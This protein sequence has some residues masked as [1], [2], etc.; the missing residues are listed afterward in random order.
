[1]KRFRISL[2][3]VG[4]FA[5]L[6][7]AS[8]QTVAS[9][10]TGAC[11]WA[12]TGSG[13]DLTLTITGNGKMADY[14]TATAV[15]WFRDYYSNITSITITQGVTHIGKCAF[16]ACYIASA[17]TIPNSVTSIGDYAFDECKK[18]TAVTIPNSVTS[19]SGVAFR[20]CTKLTTLSV[21]NDNPSY[22]A[23]NNVLFN[24][25]KTTL[26]YCVTGKTGS[27]TIPNSVTSIGDNAFYRCNVNSVIIPNSVTSIGNYAFCDCS[28]LTGAT[29]PNSVTSIGDRA[30]SG[31][32]NLTGALTI[33]NSVTSIGDKAFYDCSKLTGALT[34]PN[35]V[36][37]IGQNAFHN[38]SNTYIICW[39]TTP[40]TTI[41]AGTISTLTVYVL[42][43]ALSLYKNA[44]WW[45]SFYYIYNISYTIA[46]DGNSN[47]GGTTDN[48]SHDYGEMQMLASNGFTRTGYTFAG[49]NTEKNGMGISYT[50]AQ[51]V[52]N[53]TAIL[54]ATI[55]LYAQWTPNHTI[56]Y[57][58]NGGANHSSNPATYTVN[59]TVTLHAPTR[60][61][62]T[63]EGWYDNDGFNGSAVGGISAG[64]TGSKSY[65]ARWTAHVY[66]VAYEGNSATGGETDTS[67]HVYDVDKALTP[68][69]FSRTGYTFTG[70]A[71]S[72][73]GE[74]VYD[75]TLT[76]SMLTDKNDV[77]LTLYA[78]W[79]AHA[80]RV[81]YDGNSATDGETDTSEHV[82][83]V[84]KQLT[85]NGFARMDYLFW[86]WAT[87]P[88]GGKVYG[89][90]QPV[91]NLTSADSAT[92][93]LY[94][95][96][97]AD[98][99]NDGIPDVNDP[100]SPA[101][102]AA[103]GGC[104]DDDGDGIPN[105]NDPDSP[106][107]Q[108]PGGGC[109]DGDEDGVPNRND[110]DAPNCWQVGGS[111]T[112]ED[113]G[114][115]MLRVVF[116]ANYGVWSS[117]ELVRKGKPVAPPAK[118][119]A[120]EG[121]VF[122]GWFGVGS[123]AWDFSTP[124]TQNMTLQGRWIDENALCAVAFESNGGSAVDTQRVALGK[125]VQRP[126]NPVRE[127]Y[128]FAGWYK[129]ASLSTLWNFPTDVAM[130]N[131][132]LYAKWYA[133][134]VTTFNI[135]FDSRGGTAVDT[136]V[137]AL[138]E[139]LQP[140]AD[141]VREGYDF[142]GWWY[143]YN[144]PRKYDFSR[145]RAYEDKLLYA[146]WEIRTYTVSFE[147]NGSTVD[148]QTVAHGGTVAH[149]AADPPGGK[150]G[151]AFSGWY[152]DVGFTAPWDFAN[153]TVV[154]DTTLYA[155]WE[156]SVIFETNSGT[157]IPPHK[158][159]PGE[160]LPYIAQ[161]TRKNYKFVGWFRD[162][163][164]LFPWDTSRHFVDDG[165]M[166]LYAGWELERDEPW[167][168]SVAVRHDGG[169]IDTLLTLPFRYLLACGDS[170]KALRVALRLPSGLTSSLP[171][172]TLTL[173]SLKQA[174]RIDTTVILSTSHAITPK[175]TAYTITLERKFTFDS[176]V[177]TQ[178]G[179]RLLMVVN[180]PDNNGGYR[181]QRAWWRANSGAWFDI[182]GLSGTR[183]MYYVDPNGAPIT[184]S[185]S[186]RLQDGLTGWELET[187]PAAPPA[188]PPVDSAAPA[189]PPVALYPNPVPAGGV[190]HL[191]AAA[192]R[193]AAL[194]AEHPAA[195]YATYRL[196]DVQGRL[197]RSGSASELQNGLRMPSIP[198][199]YFLV[200]EGKTGKTTLLVISY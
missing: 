192:G 178:L 1:M 4:F 131:I 78:A 83:D 17:V 157:P 92:V 32:Y 49:W 182:S 70:W 60:T 144:E 52:S 13:S 89:N 101:C 53:L 196:L 7:A 170:T 198:G 26:V 199:S 134:S 169:R 73:G 194:P 86:G 14:T 8:A 122:R 50:N 15:P 46:Y 103:G 42:A 36:T 158:V 124:I 168:D 172:D 179:G 18:L 130:D 108:L 150:T 44:T 156:N 5:F 37:S 33:P 82:Y 35:S 47:T 66:R 55:T 159:K 75:D 105:I 166:T 139:L 174:F 149:P 176:I 102:W 45:K 54:N 20:M 48:T 104:V 68:N 147:S 153:N 23:E 167:M 90:R 118:N 119:P 22:I 111:C 10:T 27:Y 34:I 85:P 64:S 62:Y 190:I 98:S 31:C 163:A 132:T 38:C 79:R 152:R 95:A 41:T 9:G 96:W 200:L 28:G 165:G 76:V 185:M 154:Q 16:Q 59:D 142:M 110:P 106:A 6:G 121:Y 71:T 143:V 145:D 109:A 138:L 72:P 114:G 56:S 39:G 197:Q 61:G 155:R 129:K 67:D 63:F 2:L 74:K 187:C 146:E 193:T 195:R 94:A 115:V 173:D 177:H 151:Y 181:F 97:L 80:Y 107:C 188:A 116:D 30:F 171:G 84:A 117:V 25:A 141:P 43:S 189:D 133:G 128:K 3:L 40:P 58:L 77:T 51:P 184:D 11:T 125:P 140:P 148:T 12:L 24:K 88:E 91:I 112:D 183:Q 57:E 123:N 65:W 161:P 93:G 175:E 180:N 19:I 100:D 127:G 135:A 69:G 113:A 87:T 99:D 164:F 162:S 29:I 120:R 186:V 136:Q 160:R 191:R 137:V 81:A 21:S 126:A